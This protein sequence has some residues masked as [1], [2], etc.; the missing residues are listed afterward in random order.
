MTLLFV[1]ECDLR[2]LAG[3]EL[4]LGIGPD[5]PD[6]ISSM[7]MDGDAVWIAVSNFLIKYIRGKEVRDHGVSLE[8][9]SI[10][11]P[12]DANRKSSGQH[13]FIRDDIWGIYPCLD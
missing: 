9:C 1:G 2:S 4:K 13:S 3:Q 11:S 6:Q 10:V 5:A 7:A 8:S 12:G